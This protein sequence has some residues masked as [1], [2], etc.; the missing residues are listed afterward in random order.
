MSLVQVDKQHYTFKKYMTKKRWCSLW[1]QLNEI[2]QKSPSSVLEIGPG[3]GTLKAIAS[4]LG[5]KVQTIDI[6]PDL[7]PTC[8]AKA[9]HLP[10]LQDSYDCVCA[11]QVLEHMP[12]QKSLEALSEMVRVSNRYILI[13]LPDAKK[14]WQYSFHFPKIGQI[15]IQIPRPR[16]KTQR[17]SYDGEHYWEINTNGYTLDKILEDFTFKNLILLNTYRVMENPY[18]RFFIF[19]KCPFKPN[20]TSIDLT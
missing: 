13:S 18:H 15:N 10:F 12:Y 16:L 17:H 4:H 3:L 2:I 5:F 19:S 11:F 7:A 6:D 8:V 14:L 20:F 1:H 9:T